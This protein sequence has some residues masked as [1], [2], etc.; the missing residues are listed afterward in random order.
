MIAE[1][2]L[3]FFEEN[4][5]D[6][7]GFQKALNGKTLCASYVNNTL[8]D[9]FLKYEAPVLI[10]NSI[11]E[12]SSPSSNCLAPGVSYR[13]FNKWGLTASPINKVGLYSSYQALVT[14]L[15]EL[16]NNISNSTIQK[17]E[18]GTVVYFVEKGESD[19]VLSMGKIETKESI[20]FLS[21]VHILKEFWK[22]NENIKVW[23]KGHASKYKTAFEA[24]LYTLESLGVKDYDYYY[25]IS[26]IA[27]RRL[28]DE[29]DLYHKLKSNIVGFFTDLLK[30]VKDA[31]LKFTSTTLSKQSDDISTQSLAN[32][33]KNSSQI[34][35]SLVPR[36]ED[37]IDRL[38][39]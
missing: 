36:G 26:D 2:W 14:D 37:A 29:L 38:L 19:K 17:D 12:N 22:V 18:L 32:S 27:F 7:V 20:V 15:K 35:D 31:E 4:I 11:V 5:K 21:L 13:F 10:F 34:D 3:K 28:K 9:S 39:K 1:Y 33:R 23:N 8:F 25:K 6:K 24:H 30:H 16:H